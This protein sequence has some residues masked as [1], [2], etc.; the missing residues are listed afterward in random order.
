MKTLLVLC[1]TLT[2]C[3]QEVHRGGRDEP[4]AGTGDAGDAAGTDAPACDNPMTYFADKDGDGHGDP[5]APVTACLQ[6]ADAVTTND[7]CDDVNAERHPGAAEICDALDNDCDA[8]TA[9]TCPAGCQAVRRPPPDD[10]DRVYLFCS[11]QIPW[12][13]AQATCAAAGYALVEL[14]SAA[15]NAFVRSTANTLLGGNPIHIGGNDIAQDGVFLWDGGDQ[16][17]LGGANGSAQNNHFVAWAPGEP[18][19]SGHCVEVRTDN[20]WYDNLCTDNQRF[21]CRR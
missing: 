12:L 4:D 8:A 10:D 9:E 21:V 16:Y 13:N 6:P 2:A 18:N 17:W 14:D 7:D 20:L 11:A 3:V 1:V 15:E 19:G 5:N